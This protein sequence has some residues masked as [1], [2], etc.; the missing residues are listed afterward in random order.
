MLKFSYFAH[1]IIYIYIR[2]EKQLN[3]A[4]AFH[5]RSTETML[6]IEKNYHA[7]PS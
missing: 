2:I 7:L 6:R 5:S 1:L 4:A 3:A